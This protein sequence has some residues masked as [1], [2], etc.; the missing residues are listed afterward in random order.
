MFP[1]PVHIILKQINITLPHYTPPL[2]KIDQTALSSYH[3]YGCYIFY[4]QGKY[5]PY[6]SLRKL[7]GY[8]VME[9]VIHIIN[10]LQ[11]THVSPHDI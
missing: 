11:L 10:P 6:T 5:R 2:I 7:Y 8:K 3:T 1:T 9:W 4:N